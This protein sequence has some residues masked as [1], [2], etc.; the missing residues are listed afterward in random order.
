[1]TSEPDPRI[2]AALRPAPAGGDKRNDPL[3][4]CVFTTLAL[5]AWVAGPMVV[6]VMAGLGLVAYGRATA[7]GQRST[8]CLLRDTRLVLAYLSLALVAGVAGVVRALT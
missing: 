3:K 4:Y 8:R 7:Q 1:M 2:P 6:T 5:L